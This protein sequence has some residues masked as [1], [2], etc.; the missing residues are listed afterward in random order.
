MACLLV[1]TD[2][3]PILVDT[4]LGLGEYADPT[5]MAQLF[6]VI[7]VMPFDEGEAAVHQIRQ[8]GYK[9]EDIQ[10][11]L[12]THMHFDHCSG[13]ADF[14]NARVH[15][16]RREYEAFTDGRIGQWTEFAYFPRYIAHQPEFVLYDQVDSR[17]YDFDAIRLPF[18]PEMYFIPLFG[19]SRGLC[20]VAIKAKTGW[21]FQASDSSAV[22]DS[23]TPKW[24]IRLVLGL[25]D[26]MLRA[27][28]ESHPEVLFM[29]SHIF[30]EF[31]S[32]HTVID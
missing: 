20:G 3:G 28:K 31:F 2:R 11:I 26:P 4:G 7:T 14:P 17:W 15:V 8:L 6:R 9:P 16:H 29:N 18:E 30:P 21:V 24:L 10:H 1:D 27:F 32:Q 23:N 22:Y 13:L 5:W 19:H 12:L 25:H